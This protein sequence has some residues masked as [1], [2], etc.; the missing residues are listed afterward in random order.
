MVNLPAHS[1]PLFDPGRIPEFIDHDDRRNL[2]QLFLDSTGET[3]E[4]LE[5]GLQAPRMDRARMKGILHGLKGAAVSVGA[6]SI[7]QIAKGMELGLER[8]TDQEFLDAL[9][10]LRQ[11]VSDTR[12]A[13]IPW[14]K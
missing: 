14:L 10:Y 2:L 3:L 9:H 13:M 6:A 5:V 7:A 11:N 1:G 12:I 4:K 8:W